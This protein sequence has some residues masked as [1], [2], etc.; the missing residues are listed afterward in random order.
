[1]YSHVEIHAFVR[2]P[3]VRV[4]NQYLIIGITCQAFINMTIFYEDLL[5]FWRHE[6][7]RVLIKMPCWRNVF[8]NWACYTIHPEHTDLYLFQFIIKHKLFLPTAFTIILKYQI[9]FT[10]YLLF[11]FLICIKLF[12]CKS[13]FDTI[14]FYSLLW[15]TRLPF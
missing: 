14:V 11:W 6:C 1:M 3:N 8:H 15:L 2:S 13:Y 12:V 9:N 10:L 7:S 4:K 5:K